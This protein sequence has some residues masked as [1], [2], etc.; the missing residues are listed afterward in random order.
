M[1]QQRS[2]RFR[3]AQ[4]AKAE[5]DAQEEIKKELLG[6]SFKEKKGVVVRR[7]GDGEIGCGWFYGGVYDDF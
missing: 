3:A 4:L 2:R 1:N 7:T 5:R 6:E